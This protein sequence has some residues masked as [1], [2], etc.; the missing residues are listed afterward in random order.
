EQQQHRE[1]AQRVVAQ[2]ALGAAAEKVA[3]V[4]EDRA[5]PRGEVREARMLPADEAP[6]DAEDQQAGDGLAREAMD[7]GQ[8]LLLAR[9]PRDHDEREEAPVK[10]SRREIPDQDL[11]VRRSANCTAH[12]T[13]PQPVRAKPR[14]QATAMAE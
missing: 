3:D 9:Q 5:R 10:H 8:V 12:D 14:A 2:M 13:P 7:D 6:D 11:P 4:R 1:A